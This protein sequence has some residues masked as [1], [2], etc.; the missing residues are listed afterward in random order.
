MKAV[1]ITMPGAP[2]VLKLTERDMPEAGPG[3]VLVKVHAAGV[4]RPDVVQR[5]GRYPAPPGASDI[6]GL[7]I[8]GE[9]V[10]VGG[11]VA[12]WAVGDKVCALVPGGGYAEYCV[13]SAACLL[14]VPDGFSMA[15]AAAIPENYF[16]VWSN[17]F[18]RAGLKAGE[19]ILVHGGSS[20]IGS[21]AIQLAKA[22]GA[23]VITTVGNAEKVAF[24]EKLGADRV[25]NYRTDDF[26][27]AVADFTG[28]KG[29]NVVLDMV[30]GDYIEKNIT[31]M[32]VEGRHVSIAFLN[33]PAVSMNMLP[34]MLK[35]LVLTG[36]TLRARDNDF[37]GAI[38]AALQEKVW[39]L[40]AEGKVRPVIDSCF[41]LANAAGAHARMETSV[42]MG[43]IM[44]EAD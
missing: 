10:A 25:V 18:D 39:P 32:A 3:E 30:G 28:G 33:G 2:D 40:M 29:V 12:D 31:A 43:K 9:I 35:R 4:N 23:R 26:V 22:F 11:G 1:E 42:H 34:V 20:G 13:A 38:A 36:S 17:V 7:E 6:P 44:L 37:K 16:T 27:E 14:S 24:C 15:E 41:P 5:L 21:T 8:A 19:A